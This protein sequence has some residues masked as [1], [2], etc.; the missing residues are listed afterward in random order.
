M[1]QTIRSW[2]GYVLAAACLAW[3]LHDVNL[4][5][6][7]RVLASVNAWLLLPAVAFDVMSY[8]CQGRRWKLLLHPLGRL[9]TLRSTQ[10][11]YVGLFT[12]EIVPMRAGELVRSFL[13]SRWLKTDVVSVIPSMAVERMFD[14]IW[15]ALG[16]GLTAM[17]VRLPKDLLIGADALGIIVIASVGLFLFLVFRKKKPTGE[18]SGIRSSG[19]KPL[20]W[21]A[22]MI[23]RIAKGMAEIGLSRPFYLSLF[24]SSLILVFQIAAFWL[25]MLAYGLHLTVW[26]GAAVL[27]IV[28]FGTALPN[29][30]SNI[31]TYQFFVVLGLTLFGVD[32]T[33]AAGFSMAVFVILTVPL[34]L[35][36]FLA[37][38]RTGMTFREIRSA[39]QKIVIH[40]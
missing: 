15:V 26:E 31:G 12:N 16:L 9:S 2:M 17:F 34:W 13:V 10:A 14:G 20:R 30:P 6:M 5:D 4:G 19:W 33:V 18:P 32:K 40:S 35:I 27:L 25:V 8:I 1:N 3:V 38:S 21:M 7:W 39:V 29:A 28:H 23:D 37:I 22:S 24:S 36:G 11:I